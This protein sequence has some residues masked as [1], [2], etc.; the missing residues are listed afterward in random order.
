M[1]G[2]R[3]RRENFERSSAFAS[4]ADSVLSGFFDTVRLRHRTIAAKWPAEDFSCIASAA[5]AFVASI[6]LR[7]HCPRSRD[8]DFAAAPIVEWLSKNGPRRVLLL[9]ALRDFAQQSGERF[10]TVRR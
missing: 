1:F 2:R 4:T 7:P 3:R 6:S 8:F 5:A 9:S 10:L